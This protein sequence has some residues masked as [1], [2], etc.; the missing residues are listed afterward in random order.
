M[1]KKT[2]F[3]ADGSGVTILGPFDKAAILSIAKNWE[4]ECSDKADSVFKGDP[5]GSGNKGW[6]AGRFRNNLPDN[7]VIARD[8]ALF[9]KLLGDHYCDSRDGDF[10]SIYTDSTYQFNA[11]DVWTVCREMVKEIENWPDKTTDE[12]DR[13]KGCRQWAMSKNHL[14]T[15]IYRI[16]FDEATY[17]ANKSAVADADKAKADADKTQAEADKA[18]AEAGTMKAVRIGIV[19]VVA[20]IIVAL[21]VKIAKKGK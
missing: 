6:W 8:L 15:V 16:P 3:R 9:K 14:G 1:K 2:I 19:A 5:V 21:I 18:Q 11:K 4:Y 7:S 13:Q 12:A 10:I 20:A 17:A